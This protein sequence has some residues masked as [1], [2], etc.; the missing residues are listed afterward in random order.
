MSG[1]SGKTNNKLFRVKT[2]NVNQPYQVGKNGVTDISTLVNGLTKISYTLDNIDYISFINQQDEKRTYSKANLQP[3][4]IAEKINFKKTTNK[5]ETN[6]EVKQLK[7][8]NVP[9]KFEPD[10]SKG[11][12]EKLIKYVKN[13]SNNLTI[14]NPNQAESNN[15]LISVGDTSVATDTLFFTKKLSF[16]DFVVEKVF[17][18]DKY[19][20]LIDK[21]NVTSDVFMERDFN[22]VFE[23]HQR[24]EEI[25][26][27]SEL[28]TYRNGYFNVI[29]SI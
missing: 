11:S 9:L 2:R 13:R 24:L 26:N 7:F 19:T 17:K 25:N 22:S 5:N 12:P 4:E 29:N 8:T 23:K 18:N 1:I 16:D 6:V 20:G 15:S 14:T 28:T 10:L 3:V 27:L 21:P